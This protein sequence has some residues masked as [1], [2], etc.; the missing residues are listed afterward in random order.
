MPASFA[1]PPAGFG[2]GSQPQTDEDG[3]QYLAMPS[4]V[5]T[6]SPHLPEVADPLAAGRASQ[7]LRQISAGAAGWTAKDSITMDLSV[8]DA[9]ARAIVDDALGEGEVSILMEDGAGRI[10][11]QETVF[12]GLWFVRTLPATPG[13]SPREEVEVAAFPTSV[14]AR[15]FAERA[16]QDVTAA[17]QPPGLINAPAILT[18]LA[19]HSTAW[20][21][22]QPPHSI[23]L[24][25]LPHTLE[26]LAF[27]DQTLGEGRVRILSRGYGNCRIE[28]AATPQVWRVRFFNSMDTLILDMIE[29]VDVPEVACAAPEDLADSASR[30]AE[31]CDLLDEESRVAGEAHP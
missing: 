13:V 5:M 2:P 9:A 29:V 20:Q 12:A 7:F 4:G 8:L 14:L 30:L 31:I 19:E 10:E 26:D 1:M 24:T 21:P 3:L 18:E 28:A 11:V 23:N 17:S 15:A 27:I 25:L 16:L 22:G 6:Y